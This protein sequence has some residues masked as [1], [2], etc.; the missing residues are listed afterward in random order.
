MIGSSNDTLFT[1]AVIASAYYIA[2]GCVTVIIRIINM[3]KIWQ[4]HLKHF[5]Q[6]AVQ[7]GIPQNK[8]VLKVF[9]CN[10]LLL[11]F[12]IIALNYKIISIFLTI[13][14]VGYTLFDLHNSKNET[15]RN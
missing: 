5:F 2:D 12:S 10:C 11:T 4:P 15:A 3:E 9:R 13:I 7:N 8:V 6:K 14:T 1:A